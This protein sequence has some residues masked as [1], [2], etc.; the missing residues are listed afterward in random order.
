MSW[1]TSDVS[2]VDIVAVLN[3]ANAVITGCNGGISNID[4]SRSAYMNAVGVWA[5]S[6]GSYLNIIESNVFALINEKVEPFA[7]QG[8]DPLNICVVHIT[9][10]QRLQYIKM[11]SNYYYNI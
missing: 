2:D 1:T 11:K 5:I 6:W 8:C 4:R 10:P 7:V 3:Y 9:K